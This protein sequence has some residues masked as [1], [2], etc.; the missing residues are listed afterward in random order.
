MDFS[1]NVP[2]FEEEWKIERAELYTL[3][4]IPLYHEFA[5]ATMPHNYYV[6]ACVLYLY[7]ESGAVGWGRCSG[8]VATKI[9]PL[10]L[11]GKREKYG[12]VYQ[13]IFWK[14]RNDGYSSPSF[15]ALGQLDTVAINL[16]AARKGMQTNRYLGA[17]QDTF[18]VY[19]SGH[20]SST[21]IKDMIKEV[22]EEK[23]LGYDFYKMKV[24]SEFGTKLDWDVERVR[25]MRE[26]VGPDA[27]IAIDANQLWSADEAMRFLD[28]V[29]KYDIWWY[30]EPVHSHDL[31]ELKKLCKMSPVKISMGESLR[32]SCFF[33]AYAE[34]GCGV[35]QGNPP[36]WGYW[37]W[38]KVY[39]ICQEYGIVFSGNSSGADWLPVLGDDSVYMEYL[40]PN[41]KPTYDL[42]KTRA[43][44]HGSYMKVANKPGS[45][46]E[47][48]WDLVKAKKL[49]K[50]IDVYY[51]TMG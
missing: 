18:K 19:A 45:T 14:N 50:S 22:E 42:M 6:N 2:Y 3:H 38:I 15:A 16:F 49:L 11:T 44:D 43:E 20:G 28:R 37:D 35:L 46:F 10:I 23:A 9:L 32:N 31:V 40:R 13:R 26:L 27:K 47:P 34:A 39:E 24:A 17:K 30:E 21:S 7:D 51:P 12:D 8:L 29:L 4:P 33:R 5:D 36:L 1:C 48:D 25:I 41:H